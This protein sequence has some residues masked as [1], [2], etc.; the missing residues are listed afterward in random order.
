MADVCV[1]GLLREARAVNDGQP[2]QMLDRMMAEGLAPGGGGRGA[3]L[4]GG[5]CSGLT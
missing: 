4:S 3:G 5:V 1:I 2:V